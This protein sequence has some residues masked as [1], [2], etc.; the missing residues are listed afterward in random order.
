MWF[1]ALRLVAWPHPL[2]TLREPSQTPLWLAA[3][4][5]L[6]LLA[7]CLF[8]WFRKRPEPI[9]GLLFFYLAILPASRI[10]G[11]GAVEMQATKTYE[12]GD[13]L[14]HMDISQTFVNALVRMIEIPGSSDFADLAGGQVLMLGFDIAGDSP[15]ALDR[16][17]TA[18]GGREKVDFILG[19]L[20]LLRFARLCAALKQREPVT[21]MCTD[22]DEVDI[23]SAY[24]PDDLAFG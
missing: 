3:A 23:M 15:L 7:L 5:Q 20:R 9:L 17:R 19:Q 16:L 10:V 18:W 24:E 2:A 1:D 21:F 6:A 14:T 11:E 8:A 22:H 12:F 13:S 4:T